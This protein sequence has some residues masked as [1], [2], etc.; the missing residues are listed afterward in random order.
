MSIKT[1]CVVLFSTLLV[2][3]IGHA[4]S[5]FQ[6]FSAPLFQGLYT[7]VSL[8]YQKQ[9]L[10]I[11]DVSL[12]VFPVYTNTGATN[13]SYA[14]QSISSTPL[15]VGFGYNYGMGNNVLIGFGLDFS[16][17]SSAKRSFSGSYVTTFS[18]GTSVSG[19]LSNTSI[20]SKGDLDVYVAPGYLLDEHK[21]IYLKFGYMN[22]SLEYNQGADTNS[23]T[24][25]YKGFSS[26]LIVSG[27]LLG[28]GYKELLTP[29]IYLFVEGD[30]TS[31]VNLTFS[32]IVTGPGGNTAL[33]SPTIKMNGYRGLIGA[34]YKF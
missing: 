2:P 8:G 23:V 11:P 6:S 16:L 17:L 19:T 20:K 33:L 1:S 34:G 30:Y 9:T 27:Y 3:G 24:G 13:F 14:D 22:T 5:L 29:N 21:L 25:V 26:S 32:G 10:Q 18:N 7:E 15:I 28:M 12:S 4:D 31:S